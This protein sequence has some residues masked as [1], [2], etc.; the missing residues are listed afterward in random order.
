MN[1]AIML[2][3]DAVDDGQPKSRSLSQLLGGVERLEDVLN[4]FRV[5]SLAQVG[6]SNLREP[7]GPG[8]GI[9]STV[10]VIELDS[11]SL[12]D[13]A[14]ALRHCIASVDRQVHKHLFDVDPVGKNGWKSLV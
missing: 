11:I 9:H 1:E 3:N 13:Q 14:P 12:N 6:Y 8:P 5:H 7:S 4:S 2:L 10:F